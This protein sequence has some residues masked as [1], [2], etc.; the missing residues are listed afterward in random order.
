MA[1]EQS[2]QYIEVDRTYSVEEVMALARIERA[3]V[4]REFFTKLGRAFTQL[5]SPQVFK[6]AARYGH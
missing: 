5:K 2:N 3:R 1:N 4:V 6:P